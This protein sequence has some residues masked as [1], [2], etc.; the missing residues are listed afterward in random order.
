ME[1]RRL[2]EI[3]CLPEPL[4]GERMREIRAALDDD[5]VVRAKT[6]TS[7]GLVGAD[8]AAAG[9]VFFRVH[10]DGAPV[11]WYVLTFDAA[12]AWIAVAYGR[13]DFD[14]VAHVLPLIERQCERF[15]ALSIETKRR[16]LVKKMRAA[17]YAMA[18]RLS[19]GLLLR[20]AL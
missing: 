14:L 15:G 17:G 5:P 16:G 18:G 3:A 1:A 10:A 19:D 12:G 11:A 20:K 7:G 4:D 2:V 6:D 13:A 8:Q 9:G